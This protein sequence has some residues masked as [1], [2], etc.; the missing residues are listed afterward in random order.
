MSALKPAVAGSK[1]LAEPCVNLVQ[2]VED[3]R[4]T[5]DE[6]R[7]QIAEAKRLKDKANLNRDSKKRRA[8]GSAL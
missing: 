4:L 8:A 1:T 6:I 2:R 3:R 7:A 5:P